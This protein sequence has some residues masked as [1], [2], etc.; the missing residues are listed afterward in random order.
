M[1]EDGYRD[2]FIITGDI[3]AMWFRDSTNQ[4]A[5]YWPY[6]NSDPALKDLMCGLLNRQ[7]RNVLFDPY[8]NAFNPGLQGG[9]PKGAL[10]TP[11]HA[12][13]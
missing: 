2:T 11:L 4:V 1:D 13:P 6:V 5:P 9:G 8:A 12:L 3:E 7:V 10:W